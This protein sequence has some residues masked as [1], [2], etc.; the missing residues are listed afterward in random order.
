[1]SF[2]GSDEA[3]KSVE[4]YCENQIK[5]DYFVRVPFANYIIYVTVEI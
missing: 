4:K 2:T 3:E 1:L 5:V